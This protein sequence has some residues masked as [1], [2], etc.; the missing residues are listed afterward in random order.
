MEVSLQLEVPLSS[1]PI[2]L[3]PEAFSLF[4]IVQF[5]NQQWLGVESIARALPALSNPVWDVTV[6]AGRAGVK[7]ATA[8]PGSGSA[9]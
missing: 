9:A 8:R 3:F 4:S 5:P 2:H 1:S 6:L 7:T